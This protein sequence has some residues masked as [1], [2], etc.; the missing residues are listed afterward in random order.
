LPKGPASLPV[1]LVFGQVDVEFVFTFKRLEQGPSTVAESGT[2][3]DFCRETADA[4]ADF[5]A[6]LPAASAI[7]LAAIFPPALSDKAWRQGY[8]NAHIA[9][10]HSALDVETLAA[11]LQASPVAPLRERTTRHA[12]FNRAQ[13]QAAEARSLG[14]LDAF[15]DLV[16]PRGVTE[17]LGPAAGQDHHL[18]A[19]AVRPVVVTRLWEWIDAA[20]GAAKTGDAH[21]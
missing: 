20:A 7:A 11:R 1:L 4:Y 6:S 9:Q 17:A 16:G 18:D 15:D 5:A 21:G 12:Q 3:E 2:F 10:Q 8:L 14:W 19:D 13:R